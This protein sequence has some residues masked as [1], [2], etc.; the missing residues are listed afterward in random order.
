MQSYR[1]IYC[2]IDK[3]GC[4]EQRE[5][6]PLIYSSIVEA[7]NKEDAIKV[8]KQKEKFVSEPEVLNI[9]ELENGNN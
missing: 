9:K 8:L 4:I 1:I 6:E 7:N 5:N 2:F 3:N